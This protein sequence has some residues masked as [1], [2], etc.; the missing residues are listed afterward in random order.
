MYNLYER[1]VSFVAVETDSCLLSSSKISQRIMCITVVPRNIRLQIRRALVW[2]YPAKPYLLLA[3]LSLVANRAAH[4][5]VDSG[6]PR[7]RHTISKWF[8]STEKSNASL[9]TA[10]LCSFLSSPAKTGSQIKDLV[11]A[12]T[13]AVYWWGATYRMEWWA[14]WLGITHGEHILPFHFL[15]TAALQ[16]S[17]SGHFV[18][19]KDDHLLPCDLNLTPEVNKHACQPKLLN[20]VHDSS[21]SWKAVTYLQ[22]LLPTVRHAEKA[23]LYPRVSPK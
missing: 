20:S 16:R 1:T 21:F 10:A 17:Y 12:G 9:I 8:F 5:L 14:T 23:A 15:V 7:S 22:S 11:V 6:V 13:V 4:Q 3:D 19:G 2:L 18:K